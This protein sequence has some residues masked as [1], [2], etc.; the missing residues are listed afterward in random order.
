MKAIALESSKT[1]CN[2][3]VKEEQKLQLHFVQVS[4][5]HTSNP[6]IELVVVVP[7]YM[8][9][10]L[11]KP[12]LPYLVQ[13]EI[14]DSK[15]LDKAVYKFSTYLINTYKMYSSS[16]KLINKHNYSFIIGLIHEK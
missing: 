14:S 15:K 11:N 13:V 9:L 3:E 1:H 8:K 12:I 4:V 2:S 6:C 7:V 16:S 5:A 10:F